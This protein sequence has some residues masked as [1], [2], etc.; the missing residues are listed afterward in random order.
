MDRYKS[1]VRGQVLFAVLFFVIGFMPSTD[2][3]AG[4]Q[5][6]VTPAASSVEVGKTQVFSAVVRDDKG[7][8]VKGVTFTW[9]TGDNAIISVIPDPSDSSVAVATG[10]LTVGGTSV[11]AQAKALDGSFL[12]G[13]GRITVGIPSDAVLQVLPPAP[14][15]EVN[16][17]HAFAASLHTRTG[18]KIEG[19]Q[20]TWTSNAPEIASVNAS[21]L[22]T[23]QH[24]L[25]YANI[26][27]TVQDLSGRPVSGNAVINV[28]LPPTAT[29][30]V[31]PSPIQMI[32]SDSRI[33]LNATVRDKQGEIIRGTLLR[34]SSNNTDIAMV[35]QDGIVASGHTVG[36]SAIVVEADAPGD[37][38]V[39][40]ETPLTTVLPTKN[41]TIK[42]SPVPTL[43][44][45][46]LYQATANILDMAG[47]PL[48][49]V[50]LNWISNNTDVVTVNM[51]GQILGGHT[52]GKGIVSASI[53]AGNG[54]TFIGEV[55]VTV[56]LPV[57]A[58]ILVIPA[59]TALPIHESLSLKS[60]VLD[61]SGK[62]ILGAS[63][64]WGSS[65]PAVASVNKEGIVTGERTVGVATIY[66]I[67]TGLDGKEVKGE[68]RVT[69][70][71]P[72]FAKKK[73]GT[74]TDKT[75]AKE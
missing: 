33:Q 15:V 11:I 27:A 60:T 56:V 58:K 53:T 7:Q 64:S 23:G 35:D 5:V 47:H 38:K 74:V 46:Q 51:A 59:E 26:V 13:E 71:L 49:G 21:G 48:H 61:A 6:V 29:I 14:P 20:F 19:G 50:S 34:W 73:E 75:A 36:K 57:D 44:V 16:G 28:V 9:T 54:K 62:P 17:T 72:P 8:P 32:A 43:A 4:V 65:D 66:A 69:T 40:S 24:L 41:A 42:I 55:P 70:G 10:G 31:N 3:T 63:V 25:G 67:A 37:K 30:S 68:A 45:G 1:N 18:E 52:L 39:R 22:V 2:A 12:S